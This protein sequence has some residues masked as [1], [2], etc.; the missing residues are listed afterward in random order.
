MLSDSI[1][2]GRLEVMKRHAGI[3]LRVLCRA[4]SLLPQADTQTVI[5]MW[6]AEGR[7]DPVAIKEELI[8]LLIEALRNKDSR[9]SLVKFIRADIANR[10]L[11]RN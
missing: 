3:L 7:T 4:Q 10:K 2:S 11:A 1:D 9:D 5:P 6:V 8:N